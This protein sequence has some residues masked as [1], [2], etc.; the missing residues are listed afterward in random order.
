MTIRNLDYLFNPKSVALIGASKTPMSV[1]AVLAKRLFNSGFDGPIMPVNPKYTAIEGV[2]T[3]PDIASLPITPDLAVISTPP[4]TVPGIIAELGARGTRGVVVI[5][6]G[7]GESRD[8]HGKDLEQAMLD[9]AKPYLMRVIGPN[10]LGIMVPGIALNASFAHINPRP[11]NLAFVAQSGAIVTSVADWANSRNIGFSHMVSLGGMCDV[12]FGDMLDYLAYD[13]NTRAI[14]LYIETTKQARK[15]LSAARAASRIKPV[16]VVKAG[17]NEAGAKAA[18]S[19]TGALAG[20]DA[21]YEAVFRRSGMLRVNSLIEVFDAVEILSM[22]HPPKGDRLAILTNGGGIGVLATDALIEEGGSLA[23]LEEKTLEQLDKSLPN[24]WS[25]ANPVDIIG[26]APGKRYRDSLAALVEDKNVDA[27]LVMACPTACAVGV[28]AA[29]EVV[30]IAGKHSRP[31]ILTCWVG[32]DAAEESRQ[33]F[34]QH[35]IPSYYTPGQA[36]RAF[37]YMVKYHRSQVMLTETPPSIPEDFEPDIP[38]A[39]KIIDK[40]LAENRTWLTEPE[41]KDVLSAY[42]IPV[43]PTRTAATPDEAAAVAAEM[44]GAVVL[45]ILSTD[46]THKSEVGG[47]ALDLSGPAEVKERAQIMIDRV[48]SKYPSASI[49]GFTLSPMVRRPTAYELIA[50]VFTDKQFGPIILFGHG[51]TAVE[52]M[53]DKSLGLPP[54]NMLL[55]MDVIKDTRIYNQLKGYRGLAAVNLDAVALTL[56]KISQL[57]IDIPEIEELDINPLLA[58]EYGVIGLDARIKIAEASS[59]GADRL[60]IR[61]YPKELEEDVMIDGKMCLFRPILPEDEPMLQDA[62]TKLNAEQIR[63]RFF[64][65]LKALSHV[66]AARFTQIDY[67][68]EMSMVM[69]E[70]GIPGE[71]PIYGVVRINTDPDVEIAEYDVLV[72]EE[73]TGKGLGRLLMQRIIAYCRTRGIQQIYGDILRENKKM[74]TMCEQLGFEKRVYKDDNSIVRMLLELKQ[75]KPALE[76]SVTE[77]TKT[78]ARE[79]V[80]VS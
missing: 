71:V 72:R 49:Q 21:V 42:A 64:V 41:A 32:D 34:A 14:M 13:S 40:A 69:T 70:H 52:V 67:D 57:I 58:D 80:K 23:E 79:K 19:H 46:I 22:P 45:K 26:D 55:A 48:R 31:P 77:P 63:M 35:H 53:N 24:T 10:C 4:D 51:G 8:A 47:V 54:L 39:R 16:I 62:F 2:L 30:E 18:A 38:A 33:L 36:V 1:G 68:R 20:L 44:G 12:D 60:A 27:I 74:L 15:F 17:I 50:G 61:P 56:I 78:T 5:S 37:M 43:A 3:Y 75:E 7:F 6:A 73:M 29:S 9:A 76:G 65:P 28:D 11:G 25:H 59:V 66:M